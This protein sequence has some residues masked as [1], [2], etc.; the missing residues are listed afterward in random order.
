MPCRPKNRMPASA[1]AKQFMPFAALRGLTEA[2][3]QK[4]KITVPKVE[5]SEDKAQEL[6]RKMHQLQTGQMV[7]VVYFHCGEYLQVTGLVAR[8]EPSSRMLQ[9]VNTKISFDDI[10][11]VEGVM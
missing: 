4:E 10:V 6:D 3:E 8:I 9:V 2:L 11:D 1:R 7:T 5:L